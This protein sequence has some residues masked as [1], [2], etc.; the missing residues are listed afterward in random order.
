MIDRNVGFMSNDELLAEIEDVLMR[1]PTSQQAYILK[2]VY[3]LY[4]RAKAEE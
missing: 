3:E 4:Q 1:D 2:C